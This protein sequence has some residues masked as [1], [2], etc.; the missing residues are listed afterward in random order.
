MKEA[1]M[2]HGSAIDTVLAVQLARLFSLDIK[3]KAAVIH[4]A[5]ME[6]RVTTKREIMLDL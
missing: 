2:K 1:V 6:E 3:R 4:V 5:A